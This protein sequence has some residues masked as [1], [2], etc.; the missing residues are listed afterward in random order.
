MAEPRRRRTDAE[1]V[2]VLRA[3]SLLRRLATA[4]N[5]WRRTEMDEGFTVNQ[6]L[7]L[8]QLVSHG[9]AT[10][11]ELAAWMD[12]SRGSMTPTVKRLEDLGLIT[13]RVDENDGRRQWLTATPEAREIAPDVER[14]VLRPVLGAFSEWSA[15]DLE[16][17]CGDLSRVLGSP[18][19]GGRP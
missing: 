10:P 1:R 13:R 6:A 16:R 15:E 12:V 2:L 5:E 17:F 18:V 3:V 7:V 4:T 8:H 11:G 14:K 19:F 9:D